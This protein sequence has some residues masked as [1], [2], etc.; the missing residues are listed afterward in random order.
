MTLVTNFKTLDVNDILIEE[1]KKVQN[2][3]RSFIKYKNPNQCL[4]FQTPLIQVN[5][6]DESVIT[7]QVSELF[8]KVLSDVDTHCKNFITQNST[9]LFKGKEFSKLKIETSFV[10]TVQNSTFSTFISDNLEIRDQKD[11]KLNLNDIYSSQN[12]VGLIHIKGIV[13]KKSSIQLLASLEQLK[14]YTKDNL[15]KWCIETICENDNYEKSGGEEAE[16]ESE[17]ESDYSTEE[18]ESKETEEDEKLKKLREYLEKE[19]VI[20]PPPL[21]NTPSVVKTFSIPSRLPLRPVPLRAPPPTPVSPVPTPV[22]EPVPTPV[23][24][25]SPVPVNEP[26]PVP[27][28]EPSPVPV[29]EPSPVPVNEPSPVPVTEPSPVPVPV[30]VPVSVTPPLVKETEY[31]EVLKPIMSELEREYSPVLERMIPTQV[32]VLEPSPIPLQISVPILEASVVTPEPKTI[33]V[34]LNEEKP[35]RT[36]KKASKPKI[37]SLDSVDK[38]LF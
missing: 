4:Y 12:A 7:F 35:K 27:V 18:E 38:D 11:R 8:D 37:Y 29:N 33:E 31:F 34:V 5:N 10:N 9:N 20:P 30:S 1:S 14:V 25:P 15:D 6:F 2:K 16:S 17:S 13:Y 24:E 19:Y 21:Q 22:R 23:R 28:N 3:Y 36:Y 26:S 32:P